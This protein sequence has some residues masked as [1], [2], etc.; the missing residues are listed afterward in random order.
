MYAGKLEYGFLFIKCVKVKLCKINVWNEVGL[1]F[2]LENLIYFFFKICML[3]D[4]GFYVVI[5]SFSLLFKC[6]LEIRNV[7][8]L[9][10]MR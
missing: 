10:K 8:E 3:I 7:I 2:V 1:N 5:L 9:Y 6:I 4:V